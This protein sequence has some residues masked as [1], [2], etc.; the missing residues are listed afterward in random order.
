MMLMEQRLKSWHLWQQ[1]R[2][3]IIVSRYDPDIDLPLKITDGD[4]FITKRSPV[5]A[6]GQRELITREWND[7]RNVDLPSVA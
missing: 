2:D 6:D 5:D 1:K 4:L 7:K 3:A